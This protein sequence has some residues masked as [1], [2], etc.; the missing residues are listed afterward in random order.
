MY[1]YIYIYI[2]TCVY[3]ALCMCVHVIHVYMYIKLY[4]SILHL[5]E[6]FVR[7]VV[8]ELRCV[9]EELRIHHGIV[10][11]RIPPSFPTYSRHSP[12]RGHL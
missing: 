6:G 12:F 5:C 9:V 8:E 11:L 4:I 7:C 2:C 3:A 1:I 10:T